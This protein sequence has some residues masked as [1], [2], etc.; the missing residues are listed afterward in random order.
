MGDV[1]IDDVDVHRTKAPVDSQGRVNIGK[2]FAG[3][4][5]EVVAKVVEVSDDE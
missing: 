5:V 4:R 1:E 2:E 3:K